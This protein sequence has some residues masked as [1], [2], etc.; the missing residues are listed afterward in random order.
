VEKKFKIFWAVG[1]VLLVEFWVA[2]GSL[3]F[4]FPDHEKLVNADV[5]RNS[6]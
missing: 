3:L 2:E 4:E 6:V 1:K 5:L